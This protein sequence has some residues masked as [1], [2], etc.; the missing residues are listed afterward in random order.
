MA[1]KSIFLLIYIF[2]CQDRFAALFPLVKKHPIG[3]LP[4]FGGP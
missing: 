4:I 1:I 3:L 2:V